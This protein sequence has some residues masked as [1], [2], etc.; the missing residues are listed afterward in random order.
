MRPLVFSRN[1]TLVR[2][3]L[4][5]LDTGPVSRIKRGD[6]GSTPVHGYLSPPGQY[7][8]RLRLSELNHPE[9]RLCELLDFSSRSN[10]CGR[11]CWP[12]GYAYPSPLPCTVGQLQYPC[13]FAHMARRL[14]V[15]GHQ[16]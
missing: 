15:D 16:R 6:R 10:F 4:S 5:A 1:S 2:A 11:R 12:P 13:D 3:V 14:E 7:C 8:A 9:K